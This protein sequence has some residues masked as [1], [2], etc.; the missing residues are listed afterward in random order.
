MIKAIFAVDYWGGMGLDGSLPWP[1]HRED[2]QYFKEQTDNNIVVMGRRTWD[3]PK[4][5]KPLPNRTTYV[6]TN[7][8]IR[9]YNVTSISGDISNHLINIQKIYPKKTVWV[10]GGPEILMSV[11]DRIDEA[12]ITHFK[13]QYRTDVQIDL[14]KFLQLFRATSAKPSTDR[15]CNWTTYKNIDIFRASN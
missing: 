9:G 5:P 1:H 12:H 3:D 8:P 2:L 6:V 10:I 4:M 7:R 14:K 15:L 11:K 13:G